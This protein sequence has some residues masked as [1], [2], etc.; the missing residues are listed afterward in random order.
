[1]SRNGTHQGI[2]GT[3]LDMEGWIYEGWGHQEGELL[4]QLRERQNK[5]LLLG[6]VHR[7]LQDQES[8][9]ERIVLG[10]TGRGQILKSGSFF[11]MCFRHK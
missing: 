8:R 3:K 7:V 6:D 5:R 10:D 1:M 4:L 11:E 9:I 2:N